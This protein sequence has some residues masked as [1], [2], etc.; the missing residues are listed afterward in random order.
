MADWKLRIPNSF[1]DLLRRLGSHQPPT[2]PFDLTGNVVPVAIVDAVGQDFT[3][4]V[5]FTGGQIIAPGAGALLADTGIR[6]AGIYRVQVI[7]GVVGIPGNGSDF[8]IQRRN[9]ANAANIWEQVGGLTAGSSSFL[10]ETASIVL[11][12]GERLR[13]VTVA[14]GAGTI[15]AN[16]WLSA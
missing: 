7:I 16:I 3:L 12:A 8:A 2:I 13:I 15:L 4:D 5:P 1:P 9:A 6:A 14:G 11:G 10:A